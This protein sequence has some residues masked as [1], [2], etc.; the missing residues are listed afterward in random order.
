VTIIGIL[1]CAIAGGGIGAAAGVSTAG[2]DEP[3]PSMAAATPP[4]VAP[5][6]ADASAAGTPVP[7]APVAT[8]QPRGSVTAEPL[9]SR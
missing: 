5:S 3:L 1:P 2:P 7:L 6:G 4:S 9:P 8:P